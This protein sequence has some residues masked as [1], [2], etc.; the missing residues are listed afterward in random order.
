MRGMSNLLLIPVLLAGCSDAGSSGNE[1]ARKACAI[2][3][4]SSANEHSKIMTVAEYDRRRRSADEAADAA[5]RAANT[6]DTWA[7]LATAFSREVDVYDRG[8]DAF[9][10][11]QT[12]AP[13][14]SP[15]QYALEHQGE[16]SAVLDALKRE[17]EGIEGTIRAQ[18]RR[19][20]S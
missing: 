4:V 14:G 10:R 18:C 20:A 15:D 12:F 16:D 1:V 5:A 11:L 13:G 9:V 7:D 8:R 2:Y 3:G 19:V 6:D 17:A